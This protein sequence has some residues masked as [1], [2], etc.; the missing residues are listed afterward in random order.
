MALAA[1]EQAFAR[2]YTMARGGSGSYD[3]RIAPGLLAPLKT[4]CEAVLKEACSKSQGSPEECEG[5]LRKEDAKISAANC[6]KKEERA[7]CIGVSL[8]RHPAVA[9]A[10]WSF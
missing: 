9:C 8:H 3:R 1:F 2:E 10:L 4:H 5:C 7:F 6:T